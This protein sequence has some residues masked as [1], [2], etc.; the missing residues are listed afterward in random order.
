MAE[1]LS[2]TWPGA[3][4]SFA[5]TIP[6]APPL[7][8]FFDAYGRRPPWPARQQAMIEQC[9]ALLAL[10]ERWERRVEA[11]RLWQARIKATES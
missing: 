3:N 8:S 7:S 5:C 10:S 2:R 6:N 1:I 11:V 9:R 4:G